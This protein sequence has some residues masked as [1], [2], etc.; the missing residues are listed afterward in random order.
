[1]LLT[2][3]AAQVRWS[4]DRRSPSRVAC[5]RSAR[6]APAPLAPPTLV[7]VSAPGPSQG[8]ARANPVVS[9]AG[10]LLGAGPRASDRGDVARTPGPPRHRLPHSVVPSPLR[11]GGKLTCHQ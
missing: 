2:G 5:A 10:S 4:L 8:R 6:D 1:M 3:P 9:P 7:P 11:E